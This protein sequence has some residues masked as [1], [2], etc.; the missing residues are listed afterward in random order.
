MYANT[1]YVTIV[2]TRDAEDG[3]SV[4][5]QVTYIKGVFLERHQGGQTY[6]NGLVTSDNATLFISSQAKAT[7]AYSGSEKEFIAY[8][9][10]VAMQDNSNFWTLLIDGIDAGSCFFVVG[11]VPVTANNGVLDYATLRKT[12]ADC[13]RVTG[14]DKYNAGRRLESYLRVGAR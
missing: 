14:F 3:V 8:Q 9:E 11:K 2:C 7:D 10:Y 12:Y 4:D 5:Q 1:E 13:Y 6:K